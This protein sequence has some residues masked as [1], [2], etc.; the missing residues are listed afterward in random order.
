MALPFVKARYS[1]LEAD[2]AEMMSE[3][4]DHTRATAPLRIPVVWHVLVD[5][6]LAQQVPMSAIQKEMIWLNDWFKANNTNFVANSNDLFS[7]IVARK[8]DLGIQ[9]VLANKD[10]FGANFSG[11]NYVSGATA[12][13][14]CGVSNAF[15]TAA[16]GKYPS[17]V[18][19]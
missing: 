12:A 19:W 18:S 3:P 8:D 11:V 17:Q 4:M 13:S 15:S 1:T 2:I 5:S 6:T 16:G 9:F 14:I 10:P 7:S